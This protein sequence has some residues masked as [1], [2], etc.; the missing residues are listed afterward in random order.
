M[1]DTPQD[2]IAPLLTTEGWELLASLGPYRDGEAFALNARLR[3]DGHSP[4]L[5]A[6]VLTPSS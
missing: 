2:Q 5:V 1:A 6:A 4:A 3:K